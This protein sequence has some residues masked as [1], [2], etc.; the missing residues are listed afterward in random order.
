MQKNLI[1]YKEIELNGIFSKRKY[2]NLDK[3]EKKGLSKMRQKLDEFQNLLRDS[4]E[5]I[6][7]KIEDD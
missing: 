2:T 4:R 1:A 7:F 3:E 6:L 5:E